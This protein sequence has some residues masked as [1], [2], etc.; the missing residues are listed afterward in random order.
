[1]RNLSGDRP[2]L[3]P[4]WTYHGQDGYAPEP[5]IAR[6]WVG[7]DLRN[8]SSR[9][10]QMA[11]GVASVMD[12]LTTTLEPV[13][14]PAISPQTDSGRLQVFSGL[15]PVCRSV[16]WSTTQPEKPTENHLTYLD[17]FFQN[18]RDTG[19]VRPSFIPSFTASTCKDTACA[20]LW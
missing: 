7:V 12:T 19:R 11:T 3:E 4:G 10:V 13:V 15:S 5:R 20:L 14:R 2:D 8:F 18:R 6:G 9:L 16:T 17:K 1:M